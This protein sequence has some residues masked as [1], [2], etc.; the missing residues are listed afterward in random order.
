MDREIHLAFLLSGRLDGLDV[1]RG[2][3]PLFLLDHHE[4]P[5]HPKSRP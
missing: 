1:Q 2:D 5:L 3:E 4:W